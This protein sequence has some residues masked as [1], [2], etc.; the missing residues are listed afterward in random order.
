VRLQCDGRTAAVGNQLIYSIVEW[1]STAERKGG[2][3]RL[4]AEKWTKGYKA[5]ALRGFFTRLDA[6]RAAC[7]YSRGIRAEELS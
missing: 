1:N 6:S 4:L 3:R 7:S 5:S 2:V